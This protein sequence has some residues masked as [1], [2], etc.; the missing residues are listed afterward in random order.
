[1]TK[2]NQ[3]QINFEPKEVNNM[4]SNN[5][6]TTNIT[7]EAKVKL[8]QLLLSSASILSCVE[9]LFHLKINCR[10]MVFLGSGIEAGMG[11][12]KLI[13][14]Y[15]NELMT[16]KG[17]Q[18]GSKGH[19]LLQA[20][21]WGFRT[22][23][24]FDQLVEELNDGLEYLKCYGKVGDDILPKDGLYMMLSKDLKGKGVS[25][26]GLWDFGWTN[27]FS[28]QETDQIVGEIAKHVLDALMA[29]VTIDFH[30][31]DFMV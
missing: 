6:T 1:M 8:K 2:T 14:D 23:I 4:I 9:E 25:V 28:M 26:S 19:P 24:S 29:E 7:T 31:T 3:H 22:S 10:Y 20:H 13:L 11:N 5:K 12:A 15:A 17:L 18:M 27:G 16:R 30:P 21:V